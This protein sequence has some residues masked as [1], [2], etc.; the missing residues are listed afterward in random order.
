MHENYSV[1]LL[2]KDVVKFGFSSNMTFGHFISTRRWKCTLTVLGFGRAIA[3]NSLCLATSFDFF[4]VDL[5]L[6]YA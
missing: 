6:D 4:S 1:E 2:K 5:K 3:E